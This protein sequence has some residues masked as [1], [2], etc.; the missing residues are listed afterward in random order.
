[1]AALQLCHARSHAVSGQGARDE[2]DELAVAGDA[3]A[4]ERQ[5]V[6]HKVD[7]LAAVQTHRH[8]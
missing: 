2:D 8:D 4:A 7:L 5:A 1:V 6:D 3:A